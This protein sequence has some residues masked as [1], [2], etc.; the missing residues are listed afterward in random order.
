LSDKFADAVCR[1]ATEFGLPVDKLLRREL[2]P[3]FA[4]RIAAA[5]CCELLVNEAVGD[6]LTDRLHHLTRA[7][8]LEFGLN[9][10]AL[11]AQEMRFAF[12]R[13]VVL[14]LAVECAGGDAR[15]ASKELGISLRVLRKQ[16]A[17]FEDYAR[18]D[19]EEAQR[20]QRLRALARKRAKTEDKSN[21]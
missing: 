9:E 16:H 5:V 12:V 18:G 10:R 19:G 8:L 13:R 15:I 4:N 7:V 20:L 11:C 6:F 2:R 21:G 17:A 14:A 3:V 1:V